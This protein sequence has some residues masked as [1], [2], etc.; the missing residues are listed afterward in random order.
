MRIGIVSHV[1]NFHMFAHFFDK[2]DEEEL[3]SFD[4]NNIGPA[5]SLI[6]KG[7][8]EEGHFVRFF[9]Y[10]PCKKT[11]KSDK[12]EIIINRQPS[13]YFK[14]LGLLSFVQT[15]SLFVLIRKCYKDLN[16]LHAQ[17]TYENALAAYPFAKKIPVFCTVRDWCETI[18]GY[19][20]NKGGMFWKVRAWINEIV[21]ANKD[22]HFIGNSPYTQKLI[23]D[24]IG[25]EAP[26]ILNP[27]DDSIFRTG[28]KTYCERFRIVSILSS[29]DERKNPTRLL[30]AFQLIRKEYPQTELCLI[31]GVQEKYIEGSPIYLSWENEGLLE[32]VTILYNVS[33]EVIYEELDKSTLML[34]PALEETFGNIIVESM[35]RKTPVIAGEKA[36]AI[37]F[38]LQG[39]KLGWLC[40]VSSEKAMSDISLYVLK[41]LNEA[42][43]KADLAFEW[44]VKEDTPRAIAKAHLRYF[45]KYVRL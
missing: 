22:F 1:V 36:G 2:K 11:F 28:T 3:L 19:L 13:K 26:C 25:K 23:E 10:G 14:A 34:H 33:H 43:D 44:L 38:L 7:L 39:G 31:I 4:N 27:V 12:L 20:P 41:H 5:A 21:F 17:W 32:G 8:I 30:A 35:A 37:P 24:K 42:K 15:Y 9:T 16:V 18:R 6:G 29:I 40:D 45:S